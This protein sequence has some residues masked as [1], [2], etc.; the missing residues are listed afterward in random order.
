MGSRQGASRGPGKTLPDALDLPI[1][2][3][4]ALSEIH[5]HTQVVQIPF[6]RG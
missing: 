5:L 4:D 2:R 6:L 1:R 3:Q